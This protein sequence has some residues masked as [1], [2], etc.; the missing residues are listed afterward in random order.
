MRVVLL[1]KYRPEIDEKIHCDVVIAHE[2]FLS[3]FSKKWGSTMAIFR[4][5]GPFCSFLIESKEQKTIVMRP[6]RG[7]IIS[8]RKL[9]KTTNSI[10]NVVM[11]PF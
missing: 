10:H 11:L 1:K 8:S 2:Y 9:R 4:G 7:N 3:G 6:K 5:G